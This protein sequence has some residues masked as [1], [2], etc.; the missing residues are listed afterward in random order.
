MLGFSA[1]GETAMGAIPDAIQRISESRDVV[2]LS[3]DA[4]IIP[5]GRT[6]EGTLVRSCSAVWREI[7]EALHADWSE[8]FRI[9]WDK[10][11]ELVAGSFK[12][13]GY[14]Q[15]I[16]TPRS[17]DFGRDVIA[18]KTGVGSVKIIGSV[19]AYAPHRMVSQ[20]EVR[21]LLGVLGAERDASK[22]LLT[23]TSGF[24]PKTA[25]DPFIAPYLPTRLE[26]MDGDGL[27]QWLASLLASG[28]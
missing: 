16:L 21:A 28:P 9:P 13:A 5:D 15:V 2:T 23:T 1:I 25:D 18:T 11:E 8:A 7:A 3:M 12:K 26:L 4:I 24:A 20:N 22:A 19:K 17:G 27:Q 14:D 10:W 6:N